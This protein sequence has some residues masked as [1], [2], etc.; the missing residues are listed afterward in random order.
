VKHFDANTVTINHKGKTMLTGKRSHNTISKLWILDPYTPKNEPDK[1]PVTGYIDDALNQDTVANRIAFYH[2]S[3][4]SPVLSTWCD[5][6]DAGRFTTW[7]GLTSAQVRRH[8]PQYIAMQMGH[9]DQQLSN[10]RSTQRPAVY[11]PN[12]IKQTPHELLALQQEAVP[13]ILD[14]PEQR[15]HYIYID[16]QESTG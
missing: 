8:P 12:K 14:P 1:E 5:A 15:L 16:C 11:T 13:P 2:T 7:P 3:M 10:V 4:F 9:L 6:I